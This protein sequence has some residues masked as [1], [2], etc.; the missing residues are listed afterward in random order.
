VDWRLASINRAI[1]DYDSRLF[2]SLQ[3]NGRI[4]LFVKSRFGCHLPQYVLSLTD[5]WTMKG[6]PREWG[7]EPLIQRLHAIDGWKG[8][9]AVDELEKAEE[10]KE[11][12]KEREFKNRTEDALY[13]AAPQIRRAWNDINTG[14]LE[15]VYRKENGHGYSKS[16]S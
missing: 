13:E 5:T 4:D 15:K 6:I 12:S 7:I 3:S 9:D 16:R 2:A 10:T 11:K 14:T 8:K 1:R